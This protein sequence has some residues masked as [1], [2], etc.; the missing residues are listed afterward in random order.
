MSD[1]NNNNNPIYT[2][3]GESETTPE[4]IGPGT[5]VLCTATGSKSKYFYDIYLVVNNGTSTEHFF[6]DDLDEDFPEP[7]WQNDRTADHPFRRSL[8][9]HPKT[10]KCIDVLPYD[11][12]NYNPGYV[13]LGAERKWL[14]AKQRRAKARAERRAQIAARAKLVEA[15][16]ASKDT[17]TSR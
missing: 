10:L 3:S 7:C 8:V 15:I 4:P 6:Y 14:R 11:P 5:V 13:S 1:I 17:T 12:D 2:L 16:K 9:Y